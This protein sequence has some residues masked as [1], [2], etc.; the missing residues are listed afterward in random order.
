ML[1]RGRS[2]SVPTVETARRF[3][4]EER[5]LPDQ[6]PVGR[7]ILTGTSD[8]VRENIE[9]LAREYDAEE[10]LIVTS[11]M[12]T[13]PAGARTSSSRKH[14]T[15][16]RSDILGQAFEP[17]PVRGKDRVH[18]LAV[19]F[20]PNFLSARTSGYRANERNVRR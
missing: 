17:P 1:F 20:T 16:L 2:I 5:L 18:S 13:P 4:E 12:I 15:C 3:L 10:V 9:K 14:L 11:C 6:V 8:H 19:Q 7:R